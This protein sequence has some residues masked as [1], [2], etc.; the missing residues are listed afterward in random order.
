MHCNDSKWSV[1][2]FFRTDEV[3]GL[4]TMNCGFYCPCLSI[5]HE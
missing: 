4:V 5:S 1:V 3:S 2:V